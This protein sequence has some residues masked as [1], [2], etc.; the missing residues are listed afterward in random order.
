MVSFVNFCQCALRVNQVLTLTI[1][2]TL[3]SGIPLVKS[4]SL[5]PVT[6]SGRN[7]KLIYILMSMTLDRSVE[8][9]LLNDAQQRK[10]GKFWALLKKARNQLSMIRGN[11][12]TILLECTYTAHSVTLVCVPSKKQQKY[13]IMFIAFCHTQWVQSILTKELP[14]MTQNST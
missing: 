2:V 3:T 11:W 14:N 7:H 5:S 6:V 8:W 4:F 1:Y 13:I 9:P 10:R 12:Q